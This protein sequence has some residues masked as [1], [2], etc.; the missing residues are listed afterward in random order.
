MTHAEARR[1]TF[2]RRASHRLG[3]HRLGALA[4]AMVA[5]IAACGPRQ[6]RQYELRMISST[7]AFTIA[8]SQSPPHAR[9]SILYKVVIRD[10]DSRQPIETGEGQIFASNAERASTWDGFTKGAEL[11]TYYGK[12]NFVTSG[13]WAVAIRFRRDSLHALE[14][15]E[16]LQ[17]VFGERPGTTP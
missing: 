17:E 1:L 10:R 13:T 5:A 14:K 15:V 8:A 4:L 2:A 11:G 7:Y 12:L 9:E 6:P 16:W 3:A